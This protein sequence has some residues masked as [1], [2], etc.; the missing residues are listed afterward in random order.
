MEAKELGAHTIVHKDGGLGGDRSYV[1]V[2]LDDGASRQFRHGELSFFSDRSG[3]DLILKHDKQ[4][5][6]WN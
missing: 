2:P 4:E 5:Q 6:V 1:L 3:T